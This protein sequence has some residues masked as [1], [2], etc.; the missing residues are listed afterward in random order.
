MLHP[1]TVQCRVLLVCQCR[2]NHPYHLITASIII[3]IILSVVTCRLVSGWEEVKERRRELWCVPPLYLL[4]F[5]Y[6]AVSQGSS[7]VKEMEVYVFD[8]IILI[9]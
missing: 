2:A 7:K 8:Q 3:I 5:L 9:D 4:L 6:F 1:S